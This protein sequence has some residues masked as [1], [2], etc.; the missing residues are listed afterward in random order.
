MAVS[1]AVRKMPTL[2]R[3]GRDVMILTADSR[4]FAI[5]EETGPGIVVMTDGPS[6]PQAS[7]ALLLGASAY[8]PFDL[9]P[10]W[11]AQALDRVARGEFH[12]EPETAAALR[13]LVVLASGMVDQPPT[14]LKLALCLRSRGWRWIDSCQSV[15]IDNH[16][17][18]AWLQDF[19]RRLRALDPTP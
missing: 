3:T 19:V 2:G 14:D 18:A 9:N 10:A 15:G 6:V 16:R 11:L 7:A 1:R 17:A 8:L 12:I 13:A 5:V 4:G